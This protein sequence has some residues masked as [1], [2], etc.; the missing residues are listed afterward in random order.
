MDGTVIGIFL[1]A[2]FLGGFTS[3]LTGFAIGLVVSGIWLHILTPAQTA[4]LIAGYGILVKATAS[5]RSATRCAGARLAVRCRRR[6]RRAARRFAGDLYQSR[7]S[8]HRRRRLADRLQHLLLARPGFTP[9]QSGAGH[10]CRHRR[11]QRPAWRHDRPRR[12]HHHHMVQLR[13]GP[14]DA[15]RAFSSR[16]FLAISMTRRLRRGRATFNVELLRAFRA[17][18]L[19]AL[20]LGLW[21]ESSFTAISTTRRSA[22]SSWSC[23]CC[24]GLSLVVPVLSLTACRHGALS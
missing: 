1:F 9:V 24:P 18:G 16:S 14:K 10:R 20:L 6:G 12:R 19:P 3:G 2:T 4:V 21:S 11:A 22:K 7:V 17:M 5:G 8:A 13:G 23:C 15:Q